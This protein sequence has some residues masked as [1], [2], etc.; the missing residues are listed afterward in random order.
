MAAQFDE[1]VEKGVINMP[2][3]LIVGC[4]YVGEALR[5]LLNEEGWLVHGVRRTG[6]DE[7]TIVADV[8]KGLNLSRRYDYVFYLVSAGGYTEEA[9]TRAYVTGV[10]QT[11]AAVKNFAPPERFVYVSSTSLFAEN[12]GGVV[13]ETSPIEKTPFA[14]ECLA[15]GEE[16]VAESGL[17]FTVVR[18]SGIYGPG[19]SRLLDLVASGEA[20]LRRQPT[21]SNRIHQ[22]DCAGVLKHVACLQKPNSLYIAT[23][24]HPTSYNEVVLWQPSA[25]ALRHSAPH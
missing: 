15:Q 17:P 22:I 8:S 13:K 14:K 1:K 23:D 11:L 12:S 4:G 10:S 7:H 19:R 16:L 24:S 5:K 20:R 6:E 21:I 2:S 3:A 18:F 9:Y 25:N